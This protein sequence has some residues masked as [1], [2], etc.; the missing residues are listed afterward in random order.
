MVGADQL[1]QVRLGLDPLPYYYAAGTH[2]DCHRGRCQASGLGQ[3]Q[4]WHCR[5]STARVMSCSGCWV[6]KNLRGFKLD[7]VSLLF[8]NVMC[9]IIG[10]HDSVLLLYVEN[11]P[12][13]CPTQKYLTLRLDKMY[14]ITVGFGF[15]VVFFLRRGDNYCRQT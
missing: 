13:Y 15:V 5:V 1:Q 2:H 6:R 12:Q 3:D 8:Q 10:M 7:T 11:C 9:I 14:K 4:P